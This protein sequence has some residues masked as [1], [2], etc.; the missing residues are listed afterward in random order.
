MC[1]GN[2]KGFREPC[3][4]LLPGEN[5]KLKFFKSQDYYKAA[6]KELVLVVYPIPTAAKYVFL[7]GV[8]VWDHQSL[9][10]H[11]QEAWAIIFI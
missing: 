5:W 6:D 7:I 8:G 9:F 4:F 3:K 11:S 1:S 2:E 10:T